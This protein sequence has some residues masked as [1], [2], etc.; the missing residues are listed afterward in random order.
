MHEEIRMGGERMAESEKLNAE[1]LTRGFIAT[2]ETKN[3]F[4]EAGTGAGKSTSLVN[5][6]YHLL[7]KGVP[8]KNIYVLFH[9]T[10]LL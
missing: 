4:I 7:L 5:R 2:Q 1:L 8:A 10:F 6:I 9:I 3:I